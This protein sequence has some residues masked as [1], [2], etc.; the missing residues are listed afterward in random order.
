MSISGLTLGI[1]AL[2]LMLVLALGSALAYLDLFSLFIG[3]IV[4]IVCIIAGLLLS[5]LGL[6]RTMRRGMGIR[7]SVSGLSVNIAAIGA[8]VAVAVTFLVVYAEPTYEE[9]AQDLT[10]EGLTVHTIGG[11]RPALLVLPSGYDPQTPLPLVLSLHGFT[12]HY[13]SQDSYFGLSPLVNSHNFALI[14]PNGTKDD[15]GKRFW[16]A[17]DFCCG[18]TDSK[19]DDVAYLTSL[20]EEAAGYANIDRILAAGMSNGASMSYCLA[21]E[22]LPGLTAIIA[23]AGSFYSDPARCASARPVSIL[24]IH[25]ADDSVIKIGGGSNPDIGEGTYPAVGELVGRWAERAGCDLYG[26]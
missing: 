18:I 12:S 3:V 23:V 26:C 19:P 9:A 15:G 1:I 6:F 16:N 25:G 7:I 14:L 21:C 4:V 22:N 5:A 2:V 11:D 17:T 24:H 8:V 20:V 13:M 10:E